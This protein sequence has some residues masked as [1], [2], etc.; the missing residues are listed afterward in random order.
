MPVSSSS[1]D[2]SLSEDPQNAKTSHDIYIYIYIYIKTFDK[3]ID[4]Y[5]ELQSKHEKEEGVGVEI[6]FYVEYE[7]AKEK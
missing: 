7:G 3:Y 5:E 1:G 4:N 2:R 6:R